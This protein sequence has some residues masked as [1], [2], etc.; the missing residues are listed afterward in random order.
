MNTSSARRSSRRR[1]VTWAAVLAWATGGILTAL[2]GS[3]WTS[4]PISIT[5]AIGVPERVEDYQPAR[6]ID[7][8]I[9][10][11]TYTTPSGTTDYPAYLEFDF[12]SASVN[13]IRLYKH[14]EGTGPRDLTIQYTTGSGAL[15]D[16]T[17]TNVA[18]LS[19][20][21]L[22]TEMLN[23]SAVNSDGTVDADNHVSPGESGSGWASLTFDTV[24]ATG[25]RIVFDKPDPTEVCCNHYH[26][27][28]FQ[29]LYVTNDAPVVTVDSVTP[30][31]DYVADPASYSLSAS[32]TVTDADSPPDTVECSLD[33]ITYDPCTSPYTVSDLDPGAYTV[34]VRATDSS[35]NVTTGTGNLTIVADSTAPTISSLTATGSKN[36]ITMAFA[37]SD[38][39]DTTTQLTYECQLDAGAWV[40]CASSTGHTFTSVPGG[41]HMTH[42]R[43]S[44]H[45][46]NTSSVANAAVRAKGS[47]K[48]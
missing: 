5:S 23:A 45:Y 1:L 21:Y 12:A 13:R 38:T 44:D 4:T 43:V 36:R 8:D 24:S 11:D 18:N 3:A 40:A 20:G 39:D 25:L 15:H 46:G 33:D 26:V 28:E 34:R 32:F 19:N 14:T 17:W 22:T 41:T 37:A 42:L 47:P 2:P 48:H 30:G 27:Y 35:S 29:A 31:K 7:N 16:R 6:A 9:T 10:T